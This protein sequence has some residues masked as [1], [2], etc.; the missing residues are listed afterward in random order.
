MDEEFKS[1]YSFI[2]EDIRLCAVVNKATGKQTL[3]MQ[4][5]K[6]SLNDKENPQVEF[7]DFIECI[8]TAII[9]L[10]VEEFDEHTRDTEFEKKTL[11]LR[12]SEDIKEIDLEPEE[13][14]KAFNSWVAGI[15]EAGLDA[16]R[17]QSEIEGEAKLIIP[18][19][20]PIMRFLSKVSL[21]I[22]FQYI[23]YLERVCM[24]EGIQHE[25]SLIANLDPILNFILEKNP[26]A[27]ESKKILN[28][29][30][31]INPP[32]KL[33]TQDHKKSE[34]L[35]NA[36]AADMSQFPFA[37]SEDESIRLKVVLNPRATEF[38]EFERFLS[39]KTE[40][41]YYI[42]C[43]VA[44]NENA[45]KFSAFKNFLSIDSEPDYRVRKCAANNPKSKRFAKEFKNFMSY[46]TEPISEVR[47]VVAHRTDV[48]N[49]KEF[50][51]FLSYKTE[52]DDNV[53]KMAARNP[54]AQKLTE[55]V[56][57]LS[58]NTEPNHQVRIIAA[59]SH[60]ARQKAE[61]SKLLSEF[62]EPIPEVREAATKEN[63]YLES[64]DR[65]IS[66]E[67]YDLYN[68]LQEEYSKLELEFRQDN[69]ELYNK[70][71]N[72]KNL[73]FPP[74]MDL[75]DD[76]TRELDRLKS[77]IKEKKETTNQ[78]NFN[79]EIKRDINKKKNDRVVG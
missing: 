74:E 31:Q 48:V 44:L 27:P 3:V 13:R 21:D 4:K 61:Y 55:Y 68:R 70:I 50:V 45:V 72:L 64:K 56:N 73:L 30:F 60:L 78:L 10:P 14:F 41:N 22:M 37:F 6:K 16:L 5:L 18:I 51:N 35:K 19:S 38:K 42:R 54:A 24:H 53:R 32:L 34:L 71:E 58:F 75:E 63:A 33:F 8:H 69:Q 77:V 79:M 2:R 40:P 7:Q 46:L 57:F 29:I 49:Q 12:S 59:L 36:G 28:A 76:L 62:T 17:I 39:F 11:K 67:D 52:P 66:T 26:D 47:K 65:K 1:C 25:A 20:L 43:I 9:D 15:A 23:S